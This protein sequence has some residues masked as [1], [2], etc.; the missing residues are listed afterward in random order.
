MDDPQLGRP[1]G[2]EEE[3]ADQTA[4]VASA[5]IG[6]AL[7]APLHFRLSGWHKQRLA[8]EPAQAIVRIRP[9]ACRMLGRRAGASA[10]NRDTER[11][12]SEQ[13]RPRHSDAG[14]RAGR[15]LRLSS[16]AATSPPSR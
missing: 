8:I 6:G 2:G 12:R 1:W 5:P 13:R 9:S 16:P 3:D 15:D 14:R 7:L 10:E 11:H 4:M